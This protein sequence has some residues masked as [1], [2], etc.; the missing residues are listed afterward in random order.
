M[1]L[2]IYT[3]KELLTAVL[4]IWK[5]RLPAYSMNKESFFRFIKRPAFSGLFIFTAI[6]LLTQLLSYQRYLLRKQIEQR[7]LISEAN[8]VKEGLQS[9]ISHSFS[10]TQT[11]A[12]IIENY[13]V[14]D[15]FDSVAQQLLSANQYVD[16]IEPVEGGVITNVYPL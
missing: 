7:D 12:Y 4:L 16:L 6:L 14:P 9:A 2:Y 13:G 10:T 1:Q 11:L 15:H 8:R 3:G 5:I